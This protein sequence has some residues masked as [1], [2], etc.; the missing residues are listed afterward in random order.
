MNSND[1]F[2]KNIIIDF[3][4]YDIIICGAGHSAVCMAA[5]LSKRLEIKILILDTH[6]NKS[7]SS[8]APKRLFAIS[9][10]SLSILQEV[11]KYDDLVSIGQPI[12]HI[13]VIEGS[14]SFT[15]DFSPSE[16]QEENFGLMIREDD[17]Y[18]VI[19]NKIN[20]VHIECIGIKS[21][22][23]TS[24]K[25]YL[26]LNDGR[27]ITAPLLIAADGK[28]S[29]IR[30]LLD[31]KTFNHDY[32]QDALVCE[33]EHSNH[34][35][36]YAIEKFLPSGPFAVLPRK[37]GYSSSI[38]W[39]IEDNLREA[40][41]DMPIDIQHQMIKNHFP[42]FYDNVNIVSDL[43]FF[44][45]NLQIAETPNVGR[46]LLLGDSAHTLHP[47]AGQGFN[48]TIR[49]I[50]CLV[51]IISETYN[52]GGDIGSSIV[53]NKY[54]S[55]RIIDVTLLAESTHLL[56]AIF[57]NNSKIMKLSRGIGITLVDKIH[58]LKKG[59][60]IYALSGIEL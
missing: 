9:K 17:L 54:V 31:I 53:L 24:N 16:I 50:K 37:G 34:H 45:L 58:F 57:S 42:N 25:I 60:M 10:G 6:L 19:K 55:E 35:K 2:T 8:S 21:I 5:L 23:Q 4:D 12:N 14:S 43:Q 51:D 26:N 33:A 13:N 48:L 32:K 59:C 22:D 29:F 46:I 47:L 30:K 49:D 27:V 40:F 15:L 18:N 1:S 3:M 41:L 11:I 36:G 7:Y 38:V 39:S 44:K 52:L 56:N 28:H 20:D